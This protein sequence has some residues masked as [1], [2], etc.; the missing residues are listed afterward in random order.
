MTSS[1]A[2]LTPTITF[3][4]PIERNASENN[5]LKLKLKKPKSWNWELS[6][7][8]S[9][10]YIDFPRVMLY[11]NKNKLLA[12]VT[13]ADCVVSGRLSKE[14]CSNN[15]SSQSSLSNKIKS[16]NSLK[17]SSSFCASRDNQ[18]IYEPKAKSI[19]NYNEASFNDRNDANKIPNGST[20][21]INVKKCKRS[22]STNSHDVN[23]FLSD[24]VSQLKDQGYE[25]KIRRKNSNAQNIH[26]HASSINGTKHEQS[27]TSINNIEYKRHDN[28]SSLTVSSAN[29]TEPEIPILIYSEKGLIQ[30]DFNAKEFDAI[31]NSEK[32]AASTNTS[33]KLNLVQHSNSSNSSCTKKHENNHQ[34]VIDLPKN[35][36]D[37]MIQEMHHQN[38]IGIST[39]NARHQHN[40]PSIQQNKSDKQISIDQNQKRKSLRQKV[41]RSKS[42]NC[43]ESY[44]KIMNKIERNRRYSS[45]SLNECSENELKQFLFERYRKPVYYLRKC[46]AGT[47]IVPEDDI[48]FD[49]NIQR[50]KR[51]RKRNQS[52]P[53]S[54]CNDKTIDRSKLN[55]HQ[56]TI[57]K[58]KSKLFNGFID[59]DSIENKDIRNDSRLLLSSEERLKM[60]LTYS[61]A[62]IYPSRYHKAMAS[63]DN[64][65]T[66]VI[67][68]HA[69]NSENNKRYSESIIDDPNHILNVEN[70]EN[71]KKIEEVM[72]IDELNSFNNRQYT[73]SIDS[74]INNSIAP[75][76][77]TAFISDDSNR[78]I[79]VEQSILIR[80]KNNRFS[81]NNSSDEMNVS[82][83][84]NTMNGCSTENNSVNDS[85]IENRKQKRVQP[86]RKVSFVQENDDKNSEH[87][88]SSIMYKYN[89]SNST[90]NNS[91]DVLQ[92]RDSYKN[93]KWNNNTSTT[94]TEN[95]KMNRK[96]Q[97]AS[98]SLSL[99]SHHGKIRR[100]ASAT[101]AFF[102]NNNN[103]LT[104]PTTSDD[105]EENIS[106]M[107]TMQRKKRHNL[108]QLKKLRSTQHQNG[109]LVY[110][111]CKTF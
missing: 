75:N 9:S 2:S 52:K 39:E 57:N 12:D 34:D 13:E 62:D 101:T 110:K 48:Y 55:R 92:I 46:A 61:N 41:Q 15:I 98:S 18:S 107:I 43:C 83:V 69:M 14:K 30:R 25:C 82:F 5:I 77:I 32:L 1:T 111:V 58:K 8:K 40:I 74:N 94:T 23:A 64:L 100:S 68:S 44:S 99:K 56:H 29:K 93:D 19:D 102:S 71:V 47:I 31:R 108:K 54:E 104:P 20:S 84:A 91:C 35:N 22:L 73:T 88:E 109:K 3:G 27:T 78:N 76:T 70:G 38:E 50:M 67:L 37:E 95:N 87:N 45:L 106:K 51:R 65:I 85:Y 11:D 81:A 26:K 60:N 86:N 21:H 42:I 66:N 53:Q 97:P 79:A 49:G 33:N 103:Y 6:T 10:V 28:N 7:S 16:I 4:H 17:Q 105:D 63:I 24:F 80:S 89:H 36:N 96:K 59:S 90:D 72:P